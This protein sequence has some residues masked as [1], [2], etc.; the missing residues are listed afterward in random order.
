MNTE[1][2]AAPDGRDITRK[3][4]VA[5]RP[6]CGKGQ[7]PYYGRESQ[8][9]ACSRRYNYIVKTQPGCT[10]R[11][12]ILGAIICHT[13]FGVLSFP[14]CMRLTI[15]IVT[16]LSFLRGHAKKMESRRLEVRCHLRPTLSS[17]LTSNELTWPNFPPFFNIFFQSMVTG[18][19][20][21]LFM[22]SPDTSQDG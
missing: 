19:G 10:E 12:R 21:T 4:K 16:F 14:L 8:L 13:S 6:V 7:G 15:S 17:L 2:F 20:G 9:G 5:Q 1:E 3:N 22:L 11:L 18:V